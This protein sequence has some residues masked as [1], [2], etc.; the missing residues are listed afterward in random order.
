MLPHE[1]A[2][3]LLSGATAGLCVDFVVY[4][5]DTIKTRLQSIATSVKPSGRLHLF[6]GFPAV[7][8]G[9]A[10][11]AALFFCAY[12][13][14][15]NRTSGVAPPWLSSMLAASLGE[16][17]ACIVRV[18]CETVKQRAQNQ[19]HLSFSRGLGGMYRGYLSTILREL[20]FSLIQY[21]AWES[22][23]VC[24][25]G[26]LSKG[27]FALCGAI[28]GAFAGAFTT[29]FDVIKTRIMLA[30]VSSTFRCDALLSAETIVFRTLNPLGY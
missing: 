29:P 24:G 17:V 28:A 11:G 25:N 4:P 10:P 14:T 22:L 19:P 27:Q 20:P 16:M 21:P 5:L 15:R 1:K 13:M 2:T 18:P 12:E 3:A 7:L 6:A 9:S 30:E 26:S 8:S 23:K